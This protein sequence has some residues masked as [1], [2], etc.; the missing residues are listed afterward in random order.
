M[1]A[2]QSRNVAQSIANVSAKASNSAIQ[3]VTTSARSFQG[4]NVSNVAKDV[5]IENV[6]MD[7]SVELTVEA[8]LD[9]QQSN[10]V[11]Q[12]IAQEMEQLAKASVSGI[13]LGNSS[14][15]SNE[16]YTAINSVIETS[17]ISQQTCDTE[18]ISTQVINVADV[19]GSLAI[20][21]IEMS[22]AVKAI[23]N[24]R[25][26]AIQGNTAVQKLQQS[27][28]QTAISETVGLDLMAFL[29]VIIAIVVVVGLLALG[30]MF[31]VS[32]VSGVFV[33]RILPLLVSGAIL[34]GTALAIYFILTNRSPVRPPEGVSAEDNILQY[35]FLDPAVVAQQ[36][37]SVVFADRQGFDTA[38]QL[39]EFVKA[40]N[41]KVD[42]HVARIDRKQLAGLP[43]VGAEMI[44]DGPAE[45]AATT[46]RWPYI[47]VVYFNQRTKRATAYAGEPP[48]H[49]RGWSQWAPSEDPIH[50]TVAENGNLVY[51]E[52]PIFFDPTRVG[53]LRLM[54]EGMAL[55]EFLRCAD[56][57]V[58]A[59]DFNI[60]EPGWQVCA[61]EIKAFTKTLKEGGTGGQSAWDRDK[62]E[63][64]IERRYVT[65]EWFTVPN[66]R[67][68]ALWH[69]ITGRPHTTALPAN[70]L[71]A[72][73]SGLT[74]AN[75]RES[76]RQALVP[77]IQ[78]NMAAMR[79]TALLS[80]LQAV[81]AA[82]DAEAGIS[83]AVKT[84]WDGAFATWKRKLERGWAF[85]DRGSA[86]E[87]SSWRDLTLVFVS[88]LK[89]VETLSP[90]PSS[91]NPISV[92]VVVICAA[93]G[94]LGFVLAGFVYAALSGTAENKRRNDRI[95]KAEEQAAIEK[96]KGDEE[97]S[98]AEDESNA[99][100]KMFS[101]LFRK[102]GKQPPTA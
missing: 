75:M 68:E 84:K 73:P 79:V 76:G 30:G 71:D 34:A 21:N 63:E 65:D 89:P 6:R 81:R 2:A 1:G 98:A 102:K 57:R 29:W 101:M 5:T 11:Q 58:A 28:K 86:T 26:N 43:V 70:A 13:N 45:D 82:L 14:Q 4:I 77:N 67:A 8:Y 9:A 10:D 36:C 83:D 61:R 23:V 32:R 60:S 49:L 51:R 16:V 72:V 38:Q 93:I 39:A 33:N 22:S 35:P 74:E 7:G 69:M 31:V 25:M 3:A 88:R 80:Q 53:V 64:K 85:Y 44:G 20:R 54:Q 100:G 95:K 97:G 52:N 41:A 96:A 78:P 55:L 27:V 91:E 94:V 37:G 18:A 12:Q 19:G 17:N 59:R 99:M 24:C 92:G 48:N 50:P 62:W 46:S 40:Y 15:S 87:P 42:E 47:K 56:F 90:N 66:V